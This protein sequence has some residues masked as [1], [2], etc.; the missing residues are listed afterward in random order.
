MNP[1]QKH[2]SYAALYERRIL[3]TVALLII[4]LCIFEVNGQNRP[5][6][7]GIAGLTHTHVHW[8]L[9][10]EKFGDIEIVGIAESNRELAQRYS[11]QHGFPMSLVYENLDEMIKEGKPEAVTAFGTIFEH[12]EVVETCAPLGIHVMVEKPLAVSLDHARKMKTLADMHDIELLTN[13]ETSWYPTNHKAHELLQNGS[14]GELR[15]VVVRD[16]HRGPKKIGVNPEFLEWLT[17]PVLNGGGALMDFGCY[18]VNLMTWLTNGQ[19]PISVNAVTQQLQRENNPKVDD[20]AMII[21]RYTNSNAIIQASWNWPIG[22]K[23]MEIYGL[24]GVIYSDNRNDLR[25]RMA[26]GYDQYKEKHEHLDELDP[27]F[28]DPFSYLEAVLRK[29]LKPKRYDLYSLENNMI[30][31]E[32]LD[33]ALQSSKSGTTI[34][35]KEREVDFGKYHR[36]IMNAEKLIANENYDEAL[37]VYETIFSEYDFVFLRDCKIAAQL[38]FHVGQ[39]DLVFQYLRRGV[40]SGWEIK[41]IKKKDFLKPIQDQPQWEAFEAAYPKLHAE[42][43]SSLNMEL[44]SRVKEMFS[45][46]QKKALGAL[47]RVGSK[48]QDKY[49]EKKFAPH[50]EIQMDEFIAILSQFGYPGEKLIGNDYWASTLLSHHNSISESYVKQDTIYPFLKPE[51]TKALKRGEVSP[52]ELALIDDWSRS[53]Q[54]QGSYVGYGILNPPSKSTL[55]QTNALRASVFLRSV[56]TRNALIEI[57]EKTRM[58]FYLPGDGWINGKIDVIED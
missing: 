21:L 39:E 25:I 37:K 34:Y 24:K 52:F 50:S 41:Q 6:K 40:L 18:G 31:M 35:L 45:K 29:R 2:Q 58:D 30:V 4:L 14:I 27:P 9:G 55:D 42:Y 49:A 56:E 15:K 26:Q 23:D 48:S 22:R 7:I 16:G 36:L 44:R 47:F 17:D 3:I 51:L 43:E 33:A 54:G 8:I 10:R 28:N 19:K 20:D 12:L 38:A 1:R 13:Y 11:E 46:D 57:Q 53:T 32:V 5:L